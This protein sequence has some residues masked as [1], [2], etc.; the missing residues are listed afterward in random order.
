MNN[1]EVKLQQF[2]GPLGKLLELIEAKQLEITA[3]SLAEVTGDFLQYVKS[4]EKTAPSIIADFLVVAAKLVLIKSKVLLPML[5]LSKEEEEE[6]LDLESRLKIYREFKAASE[7]VKNLWGK[8]WR[9]LSRP[10][11]H[12]LGEHFFFYPPEHLKLSDLT[13]A[14]NDLAITLK[15]LLPEEQKVRIAVVTIEQKM[16]ELLNRFKEAGKQSFQS[17]SGQKTRTE[18]I[19]LFLAILHLL[20]DRVIQV[21]QGGQFGD[22]LID[23]ETP[24]AIS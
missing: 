9:S 14:I 13:R 4:L 20:K 7:H 2:A 3:I 8:N 11:L 21:E 22:I 24:H 19:V 15:A 17:M 6:I 23:K 10:F 12:S 18:V 16:E 1:Y 5:E